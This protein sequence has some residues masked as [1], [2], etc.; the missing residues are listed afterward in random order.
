[1]GCISHFY[2]QM[3]LHGPYQAEQIGVSECCHIDNEGHI[4]SEEES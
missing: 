4:H 1:M 3:P 2:N